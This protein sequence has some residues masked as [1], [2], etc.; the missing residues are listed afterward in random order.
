M[1]GLARRANLGY[2]CARLYSATV[3]GQA[4]ADADETARND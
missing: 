4:I 1:I 2:K 3:L